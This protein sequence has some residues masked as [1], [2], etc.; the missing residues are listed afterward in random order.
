MRVW[1]CVV[2]CESWAAVNPSENQ[3]SY[4]FMSPVTSH[5]NRKTLSVEALEMFNI[6]V[7]SAFSADV[8]HP[9]WTHSRYCAVL[10]YI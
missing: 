10:Q 7:S 8:L 2:C 3:L 9:R 6:F 4:Q 5:G 1:S